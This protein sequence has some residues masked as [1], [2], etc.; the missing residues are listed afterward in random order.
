ML[1]LINLNKKIGNFTLND[2]NLSVDNGDYFILVGESGAG[3]TMIL[4]LICGLAKPDNGEILINNK[5][6][7]NTPIQKRKVG[8]VYQNQTLFP[9]LSVF[10]NI[11][12]PLK[13]RKINKKEIDICVKQLADDTEISHLL[14]R[15]TNNLSGGEAQRV[16]IA[17][18]LATNPDILLLDEPL[19]FLDVQLKKE[20]SS[21]LRKINKTGQTIVHVS[22][23]YDEVLSLAN[24]VAILEKGTI[25]QHGLPQEIF[26]NP[27]SEFVANFIGIKNYYKGKLSNINK[28]KVFET[29]CLQIVIN[30]ENRDNND[31][32][33]I[34]PSEL[35]NISYEENLSSEN[36]NFCGIIKDIFPIK[37]GL[38]VVIDIGIEISVQIN[39]Q[40]ME[41][42]NLEIGNEVWI[43]FNENS[44]I[45][46]NF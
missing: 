8:I 28:Q 6:V 1:K 23:D 35:I 25:I 45:Y 42:L 11:A 40:T 26:N 10:E 13:N 39:Y 38:Y 22:H 2:I 41:K 12:Y 18:T 5:N 14:H 36:N 3:K 21:L 32:F 20:M 17:R 15:N 4:E 33:I 44:V 46:R 27:K 37:A 7:F 31:G 16:A 9:H 29:N 34:I 24:K 30:S 19:S 43:T